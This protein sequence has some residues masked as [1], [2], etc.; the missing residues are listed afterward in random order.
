MDTFYTGI[1]SR[2]TPRNVMDNMI[3]YAEFLSKAGY[4][5]RSGAAKGADT[6]FEIGCDN[7]HGKKEIYLPWQFFNNSVSKH[8]VNRELAFT[9]AK[10]FHPHWNNLSQGGQKLQA[11]NTH[12]ILGQ[13][14][15]VKT[16]FVICWTKGGAGRGGT[17]QA[18]R[19][20]EYLD[21]PILDL[22]RFDTDTDIKIAINAFT[23]EHVRR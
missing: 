19:L 1:G 10:Q 23:R 21:V 18:I 8:I 2:D 12:Q 13:D 11:R 7:A 15:Y 9:I 4:T 22:G 17:G 6:A 20:A 16:D 5:L 3:A 14:L